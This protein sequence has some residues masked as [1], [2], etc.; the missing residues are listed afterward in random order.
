MKDKPKTV[1][2]WLDKLSGQY[3]K[4]NQ[5]HGLLC[6]AVS[7]IENEQLPEI[8]KNINEVKNEL[9]EELREVREGL[10]KGIDDIKSQLK[11]HI[12]QPAHI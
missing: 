1:L 6:K 4:L 12:N 5:D 10:Q 3:E 2:G 11:E 9:K 7:R 8:K